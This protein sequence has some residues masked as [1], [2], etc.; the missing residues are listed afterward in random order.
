M[1]DHSLRMFMSIF[2]RQARFLSG[3]RLRELKNKCEI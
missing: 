1:Q 2:H 3:S